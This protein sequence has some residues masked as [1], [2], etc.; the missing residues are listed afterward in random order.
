MLLKSAADEEQGIVG[1]HQ[2]F[3]GSEPTCKPVSATS[4]RC[5]LDRPP[6]GMTFYT[7]DRK[8]S[9]VY[10][11]K[12]FTPVFDKLLGV[13]VETV[14]STRHVDGGCVSISAD[15]RTWNCFLGQSAVDH[16]IIGP[17]LLGAYLPEPATG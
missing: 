11:G 5:T 7:E 2:L 16:D 3:A 4:F 1:G 8:G 6:T 14:D 17:A 13:K 10:D 15:G 12:R 9:T